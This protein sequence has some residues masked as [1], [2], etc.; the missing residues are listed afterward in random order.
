[1][2]LKKMLKYPWTCTCIS[3]H[4]SDSTMSPALTTAENCVMLWLQYCTT[5]WEN[6]KKL[7]DSKSHEIATTTTKS[8]IY[9]RVVSSECMFSALAP[10]TSLNYLMTPAMRFVWKSDEICIITKNTWQ[11]C[12]SDGALYYKLH[13]KK[14]KKNPS[15]RDVGMCVGKTGFGTT[16]P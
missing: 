8:H 11:Y 1:M 3:F 9:P 6:N 4:G 15:K 16:L 14:E 2:Q 10:H 5:N 12:N 7:L 13:L